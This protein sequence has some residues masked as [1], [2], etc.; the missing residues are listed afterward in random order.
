MEHYKVSKFLNDS[1]LFKFITYKR[2]EVN[3]LSSIQY[4]INK[5]IRFKT[6]MLR[7]DLYDYSNA[8]IIVKGRINVKPTAN[9]D[10]E[11]KDVV[12]KNNSPFWSRIT[13]I[14]NILMDNAEDL[15]IVMSMYNLLE[16]SQNCSMSLEVYAI[17]IETKSMVL[18]IMLQT[19][20][21]LCIKQ[22]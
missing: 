9:T 16:Y 2:V 6:S 17:I 18:M 22:K 5:I 15:L 1:T 8:Y 21:N 20:N 4:C 14:N 7:S 3:D 11:K 12:L 13:E 19:V 10:I